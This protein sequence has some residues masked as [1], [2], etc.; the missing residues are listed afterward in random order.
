[1]IIILFLICEK[2]TYIKKINVLLSLEVW[3]EGVL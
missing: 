3:K 1:M 2:N